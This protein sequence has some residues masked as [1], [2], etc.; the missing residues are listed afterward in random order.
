[1]VLVPGVKVLAA[2]AS[3]PVANA[4]SRAPLASVNT[5]VAMYPQSETQKINANAKKAASGN[6]R[7]AP[8]G[9]GAVQSVFALAAKTADRMQQLS[10][11][12]RRRQLILGH[13]NESRRRERK[14]RIVW[15]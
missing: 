12:Q 10:P 8:G 7:V 11:P 15:R 13:A 9:T 3:K 1:M 14:K 4:Q 6:A 2:L 5:R